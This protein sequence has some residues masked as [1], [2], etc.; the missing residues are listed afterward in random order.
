MKCPENADTRI[1]F[2]IFE[3]LEFTQ[4][5]DSESSCNAINIVYPKTRL[6]SRYVPIKKERS[7]FLQR[8]H[9]DGSDRN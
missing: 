4:L 8:I 7:N 6:T 1:V 9:E 2:K 3:Y 5:V